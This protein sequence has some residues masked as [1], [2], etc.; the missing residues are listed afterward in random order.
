MHAY[1]PYPEDAMQAEPSTRT[2]Q[3]MIE[4]WYGAALALAV[5]AF[6]GAI[7]IAVVW[8]LASLNG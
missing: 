1:P 5:G 4:L 7:A 8:L 2:R 3:I 6:T